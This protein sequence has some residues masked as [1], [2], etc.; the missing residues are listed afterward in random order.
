MATIAWLV[1]SLLEGSGGHRTILQHADTLQRHGHRCVLYLENPEQ[2]SAASLRRDIQRMFGYE[3]EEVHSGWSHI[4]PADMVF[5]TIWYSARVVRDLAFRCVK[6]YFV[7]D[8]EAQFNPMGDG[9][10]MA[11]NSYRYGL[12]PISIGRWLPAL[13]DRQ[14]GVKANHFDFCADLGVYRPLSNAVREK[15]IC[16][17]HQPD[18]PRRCAELGIEALGIVK[19]FMPET[20]IVLYGSKLAG[21]AWFD[22]QNLG[23]IGLDECAELYNRCAA[24]L[25]ISSTNPSRIP[26]E[27]MASGLPVVEVYRDNTLY[28]FPDQAMLLCEPTPESLAGGMMDLLRSPE[29]ATAMG[30]AGVKFMAERPL[31]YG[32]AQFRTV[33]DGLL[34]GNPLAPLT[35]TRLYG[36]AAR[37][38]S[39]DSDATH[40]QANPAGA[41]DP[42]RLAFLPPL[43]RRIARF[44]YH[45]LR[46]WLS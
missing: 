6:A 30:Q 38:E 25:C 19:H 33:V 21:K 14:F 39:H 1:P 44:A 41:P 20:K 40:I 31:D 22:H 5:A 27:M 46:R 18:K 28:D 3:F 10:L 17:I 9:Y 37:K 16:F 2:Y 7:Q 26:F 15:A 43:P 34:T 24:G 4:E 29:R 32:L 13:L 35:P 42:G 23:L 45:R 12:N 36:R 8:F 11:E